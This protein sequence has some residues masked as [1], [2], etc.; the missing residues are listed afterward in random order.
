MKFTVRPFRGWEAD[1][2]RPSPLVVV[3]RD[4]S[5]RRLDHVAARDVREKR[6]SSCH[7]A[8]PTDPVGPR[9]QA[10]ST[11]SEDTEEIKHTTYGAEVGQ[12]LSGPLVWQARLDN[13]SSATSRFSLITMISDEGANGDTNS[14]S[15]E[16]DRLTGI[17]KDFLRS[18]VLAFIRLRLC[19]P[20][21]Q[22]RKRLSCH[23]ANRTCV[24][25]PKCS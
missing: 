2:K 5:S 3:K 22:V 1:M 23:Q 14:F 11:S 20:K 15:I 7:V 9:L 18:C 8:P 10:V 16:S 24:L 19:R 25:H 4:G 13:R 12:H 17:F 21:L 6:G